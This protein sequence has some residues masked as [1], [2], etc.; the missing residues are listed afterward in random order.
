MGHRPCTGVLP[1]C[2][3]HTNAVVDNRLR[4]GSK[5][6]DPSPDGG[7]HDGRTACLNVREPQVSFRT[8]TAWS[9]PSDGVSLQS[10]RRARPRHRGRVMIGKSVHHYFGHAADQRSE[11]CV[12]RGRGL[13][14]GPDLMTLNPDQR[15]AIRGSRGSPLSSRTLLPSLNPCTWSAGRI[16]SRSGA[17]SCLQSGVT[18]RR[19]T[20]GR[21]RIPQ[22]PNGS[23]ITR[24]VLLRRHSAA[25]D[26]RHGGLLQPPT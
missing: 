5:P 25:R 14:K 26:D 17:R 22:A 8:E 3:P 23:T 9:R 1:R 10:C 6:E 24:R 16:Q 15:R 12:L 19:S 2:W 7:G 18:P 4:P 13:Y 20:A 11:R 21:R